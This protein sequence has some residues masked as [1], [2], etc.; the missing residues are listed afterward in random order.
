MISTA[1]RL[2]LLLTLALFS[3]EEARALIIYGSGPGDQDNNFNVLAPGALPPNG[4][5]ALNVA[6][7]GVNNASGLYLGHG[8]VLTANHVNLVDAD[9]LINGLN[10]VRD[11]TF[12][13]VQVTEDVATTAYA[14]IADLK[15]VKILGIPNGFNNRILPPLPVVQ[16]LPI[17]YSNS[18]DLTA[19]TTLVGWGVGKGAV[20][21]GQGWSWGDDSTRAQRWG[22]NSVPGA[23]TITPEV[24]YAYRYDALFVN[25]NRALGA[26]TPHITL[27]DSGSAL[28]QNIGGVWKVSGLATS[29]HTALYDH[30]TAQAGDQANSSFFVRLAKYSHLL[31]YENWA[32]A[33]LGDPA[34]ALT[35]DPDKD[36]CNTLLEY[37][38]RTDPNSASSAS[39][40]VAGLEG[41]SLTLTY[42]QLLSATDLTYTVEESTD[43]TDPL[44]WSRA[45]VEEETVST[46]GVTRVVKAKV[47]PGGAGRKFLRLSVTRLP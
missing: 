30:D 8:Y 1:Q 6:R 29:A 5:P 3:A 41:G 45:T 4:A 24:N 32:K 15:L 17:N 46:T 39:L 25:F 22:S 43:L 19:A 26:A 12:V 20:V 40:P 2:V 27:G 33:K 47:A 13:P 31:R 21:P 38:F 18:A 44:G 23:H 37:A 16:S 34:A 11:T 9:I 42:T 35:A 14:D 10:Y 28:F 7:F 36:G